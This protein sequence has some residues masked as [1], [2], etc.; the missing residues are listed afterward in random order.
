MSLSN[1]LL[2]VVIFQCV[3]IDSIE[4]RYVGRFENTNKDIS[5]L[6][7]LYSESKYFQGFDRPQQKILVST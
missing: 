3:R 7:L 4:N 1:T 6:N 2:I 5:T